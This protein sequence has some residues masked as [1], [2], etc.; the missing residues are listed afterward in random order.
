M[1]ELIFK[2]DWLSLFVA[3]EKGVDSLNVP[4]IAELKAFLG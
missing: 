1:Y 2:L 3:D 4:N